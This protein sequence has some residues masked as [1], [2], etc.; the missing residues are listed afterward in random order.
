MAPV[1]MQSS[2]HAVG[3]GRYMLKETKDVTP[4]FACLTSSPWSIVTDEPLQQDVMHMNYQMKQEV[5][6]L[7]ADLEPSVRHLGHGL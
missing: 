6:Q 1:C 4:R 3:G 7:F 5:M 2:P